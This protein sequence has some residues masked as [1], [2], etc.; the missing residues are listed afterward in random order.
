MT[1]RV[2]DFKEQWLPPLWIIDGSSIDRTTC[3]IAS[4][5]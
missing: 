1:R 2:T 5:T 4:R 3:S